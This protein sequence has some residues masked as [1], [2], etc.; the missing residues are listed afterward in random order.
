MPSSLLVGITGGSGSGKSTLAKKLVDRLGKEEVTRIPLDNYFYENAATNN[1]PEAIDFV[2]FHHHLDLLLEGREVVTPRGNLIRPNEVLLLEG[3]L[4]MCDPRLVERLNL[5]IF[6][7]L[8]KEERL[9]RRIQR[10]VG[11]G[12]ELQ[13][14][15][16][17]YRKDVKDNFKRYIEPQK[18]ICDLIVW[19]ELTDRR[20]DLVVNLIKSLKEN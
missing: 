15:I 8:D 2:K 20:V 7:D 9:L 19:G 14:I 16:D 5:S 12:M 10:N 4:L 11:F 17:W 3:H 6:L 13:G 1:A 18:K